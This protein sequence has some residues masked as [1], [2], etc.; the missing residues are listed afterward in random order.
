MHPGIIVAIGAG[1]AYLFTKGFQDGNGRSSQN[2]GDSGGSDR[3][4]ESGSA[5]SEHRRGSGGV[6]QADIDRAANQAAERAIQQHLNER[7][8]DEIHS[9]GSAVSP[10]GGGGIGDNHG[11]ESDAAASERDQTESESVTESGNNN[12]P[13]EESEQ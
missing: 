9:N 13:S 10:M 2:G 3:G 5:A 1:I 8:N 7:N 11:G 12:E 6:T 4:G